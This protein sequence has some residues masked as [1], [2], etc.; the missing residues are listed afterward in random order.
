MFSAQ[1]LGGGGCVSG[2]WSLD[3]G[4]VRKVHKGCTGC[5]RHCVCLLDEGVSGG[6]LD[7]YVNLL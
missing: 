2:C 1:V 4:Y 6:V 7:E 3:D 5:Y